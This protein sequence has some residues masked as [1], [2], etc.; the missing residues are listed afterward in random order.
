[1]ETIMS[2]NDK[3]VLRAT[4]SAV[5]QSKRV[6]NPNREGGQSLI[7]LQQKELLTFTADFS[8]FWCAGTTKCN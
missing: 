8:G 4:Q 1:M 3:Y 6:C 7:A 5:E 2:A